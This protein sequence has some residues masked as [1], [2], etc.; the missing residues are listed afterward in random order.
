MS[1]PTACHPMKP[2]VGEK[3][4]TAMQLALAARTSPGL[5]TGQV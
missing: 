5:K 2:S 4:T 1:E 3:R